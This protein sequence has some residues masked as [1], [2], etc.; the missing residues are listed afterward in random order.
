MYVVPAE[1]SEIDLCREC[2]LI[3][4]DFHE[5]DGLP[6]RTE[7]ELK[8]ERSLAEGVRAQ[9]RREVREQFERRMRDREPRVGHWGMQHWFLLEQI[10]SVL[11]SW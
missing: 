10:R 8:A 1:G 6:R 4:F 5:M 9:R 3:W 7:G 2:Q 11:S